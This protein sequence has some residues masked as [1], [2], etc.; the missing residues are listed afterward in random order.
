MSWFRVDDGS[1]FHA[2]VV[3]AGNDGW[4]AVC[5]AG[6]WSS[7]QG[8][9]GFVPDEIAK[10]I[11][12]AKVWAKATAA[13]LVDKCDGGKRIHDF[14]QWN[15]S[16]SEVEKAREELSEKRRKAGLAGNAKRWSKPRKDVAN[17]SQVRDGCDGKSD[18]GCDGHELANASPHPTPPQSIQDPPYSPPVGDEAGE[19][20]LPGVQP[21]DAA[22]AKPKG[23]TVKTVLPDSWSPKQE[24]VEQAKLEGGKDQAW[25]EDQA[26]RMRDWAAA[27]GERAADW[28][29][30]FRNWLRR[31]IDDGH[32]PHRSTSRQPGGWDPTDSMEVM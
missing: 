15:P 18:T 24:H 7:A 26:R 12:P 8:T 14:L 3:K 6:A 11:A 25:V 22:K 27:K 4:G 20:T 2:K 13:G 10:L 16:A 1:A 32:R 21:G 5:R 30:R 9:D 29:A 17:E 19:P 23:R 31:G 28:D